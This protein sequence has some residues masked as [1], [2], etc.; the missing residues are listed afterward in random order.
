MVY[1]YIYIHIYMRSNHI[2]YILSYYSKINYKLFCYIFLGIYIYTCQEKYSKLLQAIITLSFHLVGREI[3]DKCYYHKCLTCDN[4]ITIPDCV[5]VNDMHTPLPQK[6]WKFFM[7]DAE[8]A[9]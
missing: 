5:L 1:T 2:I 4:N 6:W 3:G 7:K 8:C 9:E